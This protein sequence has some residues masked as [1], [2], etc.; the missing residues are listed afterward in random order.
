MSRRRFSLDPFGFWPGHASLIRGLGG[1]EPAEL[2][3]Y[4]FHTPYVYSGGDRLTFYLRFNGLAATA[5]ALTI[6]VHRLR[7]KTRPKVDLVRKT[8]YPLADLS[9]EIAID[10]AAVD[11]DS[12]AIVG[13]LDRDAEAS[14]AELWIDA[15]RSDDGAPFGVALAAAQQRIFGEA[16]TRGARALLSFDPATIADPVSQLCTSRQFDEP[17]YARWIER[18]GLGSV[19]LHR[20][21]WEFVYILQALERYGAIRPGARGIGF[22]VGKERL[23][24]LLAAM[25]CTIVATDLPTGDARAATWSTGLQ[26]SDGLSGLRC[27]ELCDDATFDARVSF[28]P[29]DM[30][31]IPDDLTGFDFAWSSCAF[32]HLGSIPAGLRFVERTLDCVR[33]GGLVVHTT[34]FNLTSNGAT[35]DRGDTVLFRRRDIER[36]AARLARQG[37]AVAPIKYDMGNGL[38]DGYVDVPPYT[39]DAQLKIALAGHVTTSFGILVRKAMEAPRRSLFA[40]PP[41]CADPTFG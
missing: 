36:L 10:I 35:I 13:L 29:V 25:G 18:L 16:A 20:K 12:Y 23:P 7:G 8:V 9:G 3:G 32:E 22:G 14:A 34:E 21:Q 6:K 2:P 19:H 41:A 27:P 5:G 37:H 24:A 33:P 4:A 39:G 28:R 38:I 11:G 1:S 15:E 30:S 17:D 31:A 26:H 40:R